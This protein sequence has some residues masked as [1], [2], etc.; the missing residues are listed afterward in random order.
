[1][2]ISRILRKTNSSKLVIFIEVVNDNVYPKI[3]LQREFGLAD[4]RY[5]GIV[6]TCMKHTVSQGKK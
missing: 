4:L 2:S 5:T 1:M 3:S 6:S